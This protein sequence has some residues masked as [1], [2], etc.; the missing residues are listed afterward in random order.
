MSGDAGSSEELDLIVETARQMMSATP[1]DEA[2]TMHRL[3]EAGLMA[4]ARPEPDGGG[5]LAAAAAVVRL[6]GELA[7]AGGYA[8]S[9]ILGGP[10]LSAAGLDVGDG[11]LAAGAAVGEVRRDGDRLQVD[12][13]A[14]RVAWASDADHLVLVAAVG[15]EDLVARVA[16][17]DATITPGRNLAGEARDGVRVSASIGPGQWSLLPGARAELRGRGALARSAAMA[18]AAAGAL[19]STVGYAGERVQFGRPIARFQVVQ[20]L[21]AELAVEVEAMTA[22]TAAAVEV[23]AADGFGTDRARFAVAV[24]KAQTSASAGVVARIAH[25]VHGA[26]GTTQEHPLHHLSTRLWSWREDFGSE[27]AWQADIGQAALDADVWEVL[28]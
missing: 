3:S 17:A 4:L 14:G 21:V 11:W 5:W 12:V 25:Q 23:C 10:L 7:I 27:R 18:G 16:T 20:H 19:A 26:I 9:A 24:A 28:T 8:D 15:E 6:S 2:A 13:D 1:S 22:A